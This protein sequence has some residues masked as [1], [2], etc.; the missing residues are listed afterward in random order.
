ME[1]VKTGATA[2]IVN[3][4]RAAT[5][6]TYLWMLPIYG[7]GGLL[8][9]KIADLLHARR[10]PRPARVAAY[11]PAIYAVEAATGAALRCLLRKC[12]WDYSSSKGLHLG[13]LVRLD[14]APLWLAVGYLF[15]PVRA[16]A[17]ALAPP[18]IA[19]SSSR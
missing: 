5:A 11:L 12:P 18:V 19:R 14:Y 3:R 8:L 13:G 1:V 6:R 2:A 10:W 4:D 7:A 9:D 15:E 16:I 17:T